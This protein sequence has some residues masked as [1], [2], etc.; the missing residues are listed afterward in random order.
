MQC[1]RKQCKTLEFKA[2]RNHVTRKRVAPRVVNALTEGVNTLS[3][4]G[5]EHDKDEITSQYTSNTSVNTWQD[6]SDSFF[7]GQSA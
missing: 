7:A 5:K 3:K 4:Q 6:S 1:I 2:F